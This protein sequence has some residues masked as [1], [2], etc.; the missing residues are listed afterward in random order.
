MGDCKGTVIES[1]LDKPRGATATLLVQNGT[2][3]IGDSVVTGET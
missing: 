1:R 3:R 2:L